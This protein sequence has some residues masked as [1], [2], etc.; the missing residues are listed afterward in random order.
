MLSIAICDNEKYFCIRERE[1]IR[2]Y[3]ENNSHKCTID[4]FPSGKEFLKLKESI[5]K[6]D[7]IFLDINMKEI[8]GIETAKA[9]RKVTKNVYIVFVTAFI[10][11]ALEGY[12]VDA[13]RCLLKDDES[14]EKA[15]NEC[16]ESILQKMYCEE[17][18]ITF[19]FQEGK[20]NVCPEAIVYIESNLHKLLFHM[21]GKMQW[22]IQCMPSWMI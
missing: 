1:L 11:Y 6:Y 16:L 3:M 9:I 21:S 14:F 12:K 13:V 10:N 2:R 22:N 20:R 5:S 7:I 4:L 19:E 8:D 17:H 15:V 18:K